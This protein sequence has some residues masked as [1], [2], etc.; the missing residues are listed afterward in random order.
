MVKLTNMFEN[1]ENVIKGCFTWNMLISK[2]I[3]RS[4]YNLGL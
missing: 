2:V 3:V 1:N 4:K